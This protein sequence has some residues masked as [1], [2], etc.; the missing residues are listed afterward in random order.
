[1]TPEAAPDGLGERFR[2]V[3]DEQPRHCRIKP[4]LDQIVDQRLDHGGMFARALDQPEWMLCALA[5]DADRRHQHDIFSDMD[6]V[7]LH[8]HDVEMAEVRHHPFIHARR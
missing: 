7:D 4:A 3:D 2:A 5:V 1:M 8:H 6:A